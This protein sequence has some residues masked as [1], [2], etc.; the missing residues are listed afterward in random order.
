MEIHHN[1]FIKQGYIS[2][3]E[4]LPEVGQ[5]VE[6]IGTHFSDWNLESLIWKS[7]G[8]IGG[9]GVWSVKWVKNYSH[10]YPTSY[11]KP[12]SKEEYFKWVLDWERNFQNY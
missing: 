4:K 8:R 7:M 2:V 10:E 5:W 9:H 12:V 1:P 6:V 3:S 11:W